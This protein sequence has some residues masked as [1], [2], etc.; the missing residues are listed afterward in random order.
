MQESSIILTPIPQADGVAKKRPA[1][2]LRKMP[3]HKDF[4][5]CG[6]S[7][8]LKQ[9]IPKFDELLTENDE[10]FDSSRLISTSV[11]RLGFLTVIPIKM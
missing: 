9:Y 10:D 4:L 7:T 6:I 8:Q 11:I 1:L 3:K 2:V 5:V